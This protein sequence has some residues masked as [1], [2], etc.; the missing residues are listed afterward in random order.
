MH[1]KK[2]LTHAECRPKV[3]LI[4]FE[5]KPQK[6]IREIANQVE[7]IQHLKTVVGPN[8]E[9]SDLRHPTGLCDSCRKNF[10]STSAIEEEKEF[11][12][13]QYLYKVVV[14]SEDGDQTCEF[15]ICQ[16]VRPTSFLEKLPGAKVGKKP[17]KTSKN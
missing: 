10:F 11:T 15:I 2:K 13:P 7:W 9:I 14:S 17:M 16:K 12:I 1:T 5:V 8:F 3:C 6:S 4:C